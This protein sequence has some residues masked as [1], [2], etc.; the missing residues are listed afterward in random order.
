MGSSAR[1]AYRRVRELIARLGVRPPVGYPVA[2][3]LH[4]SL[5]DQLVE[6][7]DQ[8]VGPRDRSRFISHAVRRAL[9]ELARYEAIESAIG[10]I[11]DS[12]HEWDEDPARWVRDQRFDRPA[13]S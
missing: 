4:I 8:R 6:D 1:T 2:M 11:G 5:D 9:D 12:G 10:S 7:L 3:R 13:A